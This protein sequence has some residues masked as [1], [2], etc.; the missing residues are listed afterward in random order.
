[1]VKDLSLKPNKIQFTHHIKSSNANERLKFAN[2]IDN[3]IRED[4]NFIDKLIMTDEAYF[5]L[6]G[7]INKQNLIYWDT[8]NPRIVVEKAPHLKRITVFCAITSKR[9]YG[10]FYFED[11]KGNAVTVNKVNYRYMLEHS[12]ILTIGNVD[13]MWYQQ[14]G[15]PPHIARKTITFLKT[16]FGN[17][18]ISKNGNINWL[19]RSPD[20]S[21][22]DFF[23]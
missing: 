8:K 1:M 12:V 22:L 6:D 7:Y 21:P 2:D 11:K 18:I 14:D 20:L 3:L 19:T 23:L 16:I 9:I 10:P 4:E 13:E 15:V 5:Q 17:R